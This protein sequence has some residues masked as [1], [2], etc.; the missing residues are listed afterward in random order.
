MS[1]ELAVR[2][3]TQVEEMKRG[4]SMVRG[5]FGKRAV[6]MTLALAALCALACAEGETPA[7][8]DAGTITT[9]FTAGFNSMVVNSI[10]MISA[11]VP[12]GV[13]LAGVVFMVKKAMHWFKGV[14]NG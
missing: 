13:T 12:I 6:V 2:K 4:L 11:M 1:E 14:A 9:A 10:N 3:E 7:T 5:T 8:I